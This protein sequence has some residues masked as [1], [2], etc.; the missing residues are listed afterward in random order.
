M[1][2]TLSV[3]PAVAEPN[4]RYGVAGIGFKPS[5]V[6][7]V[8]L[9]HSQMR[10]SPRERMV[11]VDADG[12]FTVGSTSHVEGTIAIEALRPTVKQ[13]RPRRVRREVVAKAALTVK[14]TSED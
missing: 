10:H 6:I 11:T 8:R 4:T 5:E 9:T 12:R 1:A 14:D 3:S 13:P 2:A 7:M